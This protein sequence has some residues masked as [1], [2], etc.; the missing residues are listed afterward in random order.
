MD[1]LIVEIDGTIDFLNPEVVKTIQSDIKAGKLVILRGAVDAQWCKKVVNYL[2]VVGSSSLPNYSS[3][4]PGAAN[5]HR[6]NDSDQRSFVKGCFHQFV[7]YPWNQDFLN[8]FDRLKKF[9]E[10]KN[11]VSNISAGKFLL[12][13]DMNYTARIA[14]QFYP[15]S[16]GYLNLHR[17]PVFEHQLCVPTVTLSKK[18]TDYQKGG[19]VFITNKGKKINIDDISEV[20]DVTLFDASLVH[21][22]DAIDPDLD[23]DWLNF[24]GRWMLLLAVNKFEHTDAP[25]SLEESS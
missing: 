12:D 2:S 16:K 10:L 8:F 13:S 11:L 23:V 3:I 20:G 24:K 14:A 19:A 6:I 4:V 1:K 21:G 25:D 22:V 18:G 7:F 17:D 15:S 5:F 9:Y